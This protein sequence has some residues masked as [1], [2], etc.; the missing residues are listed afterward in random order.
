MCVCISL[1]VCVCV[2]VF[3]RMCVCVCVCVCTRIHV[4][5][6]VISNTVEPLLTNLPGE[7]YAHLLLSQFPRKLSIT[8]PCK[9]NPDHG[10]PLS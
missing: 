4:D 10:S 2:C 8:F 1:C 3:A 6:C 9:G 7:S 5:A